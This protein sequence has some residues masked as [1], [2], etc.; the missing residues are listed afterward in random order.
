MKLLIYSHYFAPSIGGVETIVL[1][2]AG[3]LAD[4]RKADGS[5]E[6]DVT[7]VTQTGGEEDGGLPFRVVRRPNL[8]Q[9]WR[10]IRQS[11]II[12]VAGP[13]LAPLLIARL[14]GKPVIVEHHG[15]QTVCPNGQLFIESSCTPCPGHFMAHRHR[16]CLRCN[17]KDGWFFSTRLWLLTFA[18]RFLC[19]GA[20][21]NIVPTS[22]LAEIL[23]LPNVFHVAHGLAG[24]V[25]SVPAKS[26]PAIPLIAFQGRLVSTKGV[27]V[28]LNA[29]HILFQQGRS[30]DL[31]IIGDGPERAHLEKLVTK[32]RLT[33][34]VTFVGRLPAP[35][36]DSALRQCSF[37]V[38]PSLGGEVFGLVLLE[39]MLRG[40][41]IIASDLG[42]YAEVLGDSGCTFRTG[43]AADLARQMALLLDDQTTAVRLS[44]NAR[45][46]GQKLFGERTMID[47]HAQLFR[48]LR[49]APRP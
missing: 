38:L 47:R 1:S 2:L 36:L 25:E 11:Q 43:D 30:F 41:P 45:E 49:V 44:Q 35:Q 23:R 8:L 21:A 32:L 7:V 28:L 40:L 42:A 48:E 5:P 10:L 24:P 6:F 17:A 14:S 9:L 12:H 33:E 13:A 16:V 20:A 22:W 26:S 31:L 34:R 29:A 18:R 39:N 46:R 3:G 37:L 4:L 19:F 15:F 27:S